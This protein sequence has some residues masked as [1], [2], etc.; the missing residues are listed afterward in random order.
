MLGKPATPLPTVLGAP[1]ASDRSLPLS[2]PSRILRGINPQRES[3]IFA[4]H[5]TR[6]LHTST[7]ALTRFETC[8][9]L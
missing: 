8:A 6:A 2:S 3:H 9:S 1:S 7:S 5:H 4:D